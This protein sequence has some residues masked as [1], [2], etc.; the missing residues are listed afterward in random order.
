MNTMTKAPAHRST[1]S[2]KGQKPP[3]SDRKDARRD[4]II[5][6]SAD[7]F[8]VDA[9]ENVSIRAI[10]RATGLTRGAIYYYFEGKEDI[11]CATVLDGLRR[12]RD[13]IG[14]AM[15]RAPTT[16]RGQLMAFVDAYIDHFETERPVFNNLL[17]FF[18]G[19]RPSVNLSA[20]LLAAANTEIAKAVADVESVIEAGV[21]GDD[22][23]C[24]DPRFAVM[25]LWG[26]LVTTVQ[27]DA[28]NPR[29]AA[30]GRDSESLRASMKR[31]SLTIVG[32][33]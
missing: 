8:A 13:M 15:R 22:F 21:Q 20:E 26:F 11:Y 18:F 19:M 17:R 27:M 23:D 10:E 6:R 31:M 33:R 5:A 14:H 29:M 12:V 30:V 28:D 7:L 4:L 16:P 2:K 9:Y 32:A 3:S 24:P 1:S 25:T